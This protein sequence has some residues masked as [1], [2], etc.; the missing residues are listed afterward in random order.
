MQER[1]L[2]LEHILPAVGL[3]ETSRHL[4]EQSAAYPGIKNAHTPH[5]IYE[6]I[7]SIGTLTGVT[8][9]AETLVESLEERTNII[10]HKLKFIGDDQKPLVACVQDL[11]TK[12]H[13]PHHYLDALVRLAGGIPSLDKQPNI[14]IIIPDGPVASVVG[15]LPALLASPTWA[16]TPAVVN[17]QVFILQD[18]QALR[19]PGLR[20][21]D[22]AEILAEIISSKYFVFGHEGNAWIR[23]E[24]I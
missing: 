17:S 13:S 19:Q 20:V 12:T 4:I 5:E 3:D 2:S 22:D 10:A 7:R 11:S 15:E 18:P 21:A 1:G 9:R 14:L 6:A 23:F 24:L 16:T 8:D